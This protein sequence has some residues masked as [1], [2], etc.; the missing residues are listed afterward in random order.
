MMK[1]NISKILAMIGFI[2]LLGAVGKVD[3]MS[4]IHQYYPLSKTIIAICVGIILM[5][6]AGVNLKGGE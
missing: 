1:K 5:I 4:E 2:I 3:Y 6:P